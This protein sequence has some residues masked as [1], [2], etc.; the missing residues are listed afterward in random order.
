M[1][2]KFNFIFKKKSVQQK[3]KML[4]LMRDSKYDGITVTTPEE[5]DSLHQEYLTNKNNDMAKKLNT[6][7]IEDAK[8][9]ETITD[10]TETTAPTEAEPVGYMPL[11]GE[12]KGRSY[13]KI[14]YG[15]PD[16]N[17]TVE[18]IPEPKLDNAPL[19]PTEE[20]KVDPSNPNAPKTPD[21]SKTPVNSATDDMSKKEKEDAADATVELIMFAYENLNKVGA[22]LGKVDLDKLAIEHKSGE[23]DLNAQIQV[24]ANQSVSLEEFITEVNSGISESMVVT[25]SFK[26]K[27]TPPLKRVCIKRGWLINDEMQ[28]GI[29]FAQDILMKAGL[30]MGMRKSVNFALDNIRAEMKLQ[31]EEEEQT[32]KTA[33]KPE[34]ITTPPK[35][36]PIETRGEDVKD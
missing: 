33:V 10:T 7:K 25:Q 18:E 30:I 6:D 5:L 1:L 3:Q 32:R 12:V 35:D 23:I 21:A 36:E 14:E 17:K 2:R 20:Q 15:T 22:N 31:R 11:D 24:S 28:V 26:D 27:V 29:Y 34:S 19:P 16:Q 4:D 8:L 9:D 13:N